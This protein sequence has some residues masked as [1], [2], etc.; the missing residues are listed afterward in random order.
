MSHV[1]DPSAQL[2]RQA[3]REMIREELRAFEAERAARP[4]SP[5]DEL[6]VREVAALKKV[7][8]RTVYAWVAE[9]RL[10]PR[11]T[12]GGHLRFSRLEVE[13][14]VIESAPSR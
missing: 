11:R 9:G 14:A 7:S 1:L 6:T 2:L 5:D 10:T 13:R 4:K 3:I 12:P 8:T